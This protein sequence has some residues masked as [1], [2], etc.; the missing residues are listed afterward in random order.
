MSS[1][2]STRPWRIDSVYLFDTA[3]LEAEQR[4]RGVQVGTAASVPNRLWE[5]AEIFPRATNPL[6]CV[7]SQ[8]AAMLEPFQ[9]GQVRRSEATPRRCLSDGAHLAPE[10]SRTNSSVV[11]G[12]PG[13]GS[14]AGIRGQW[15]SCQ[16]PYLRRQ[17]AAV[18]DGKVVR[19]G[20]GDRKSVV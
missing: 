9:A 6:L 11:A 15:A 18:G 19:A 3:Q 13:V 12:D 1:R 17:P 5:A 20:P 16:G 14:P 2:A 7:S 4:A 10:L 8:Q